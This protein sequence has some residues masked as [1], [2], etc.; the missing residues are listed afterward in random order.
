M[1]GSVA[2]P[3]VL[4]PFQTIVEVGWPGS[5]ILANVGYG[6]IS[7][8]RDGGLWQFESQLYRPGEDR[9]GS[10]PGEFIIGGF[11]PGLSGGSPGDYAYSNANRTDPPDGRHVETA[12]PMIL[13]E[14]SEMEDFYLWHTGIAQTGE[15]SSV[16]VNIRKILADFSTSDHEQDLLIVEIAGLGSATAWDF[17]IFERDDDSDGPGTFSFA[18]DTKIVQ[19]TR[20][21][22]MANT[23]PLYPQIVNSAR[24]QFPF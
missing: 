18:A 2:N 20:P 4:D 24:I 19:F 13:P 6:V 17:R 15:R 8:W 16:I 9:V 12:D 23:G 1:P 5:D 22:I 3:V 14:V 10:D 7:A 11:Q 21:Q